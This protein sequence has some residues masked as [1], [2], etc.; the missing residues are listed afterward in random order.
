MTS[1]NITINKIRRINYM[2]NGKCALLEN[3]NNN[4][5]LYQYNYFYICLTYYT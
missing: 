3:N 5:K 2:M 4:I 1:T